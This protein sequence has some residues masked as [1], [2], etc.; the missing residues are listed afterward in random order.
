MVW[1]DGLERATAAAAA[2]AGDGEV[3]S[4]PKI[5]AMEKDPFELSA[6]EPEED[7]NDDVDDEEDDLSLLTTILFLPTST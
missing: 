5:L 6:F 1:L 3:L 4:R 7:D 2:V